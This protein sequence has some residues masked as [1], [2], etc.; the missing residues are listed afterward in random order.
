MKKLLLLTILLAG[1]ITT[2]TAQTA[3]SE[4]LLG[5]KITKHCHRICR[6]L[7]LDEATSG[8]LEKVY[9]DYMNEIYKVRKETCC[10]GHAECDDNNDCAEN[11]QS[12]K[13]LD[14][15]F[16]SKFIRRIKIAEVQREYYRELRKFLSPRQAM[17]VIENRCDSRHHKGTIF[18]NHHSL[19]R[20]SDC[21]SRHYNNGRHH[22]RSHNHCRR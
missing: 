2:T 22:G 16:N 8:K 7:A 10:K 15:K 1:Y 19:R 17:I 14:A 13:Q 4:A 3:N 9:T 18:N 11:I 21:D 12:D 20:H 6:R 5:E